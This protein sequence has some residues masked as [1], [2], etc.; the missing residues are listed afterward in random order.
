[1][2]CGAGPIMEGLPYSHRG[3]IQGCLPSLQLGGGL[4]KHPLPFLVTLDL[5]EASSQTRESTKS[6]GPKEGAPENWYNPSWLCEY[7]HI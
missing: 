6:L 7:P 2:C 3:Y 1:M 5:G 4:Q